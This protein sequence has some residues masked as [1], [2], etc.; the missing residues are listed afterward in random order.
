MKPVSERKAPEKQGKRCI[1]AVGETTGH[2]HQFETEDTAVL[3]GSRLIVSAADRLVHEEHA[4][5]VIEPGIGEVTL[6]REYSMGSL[7]SA[8]D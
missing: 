2:K 5:H 8:A 1:L 7:R 4:A 6:Q 3:E